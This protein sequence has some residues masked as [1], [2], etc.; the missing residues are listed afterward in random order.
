MQERA[1]RSMVGT[2]SRTSCR[3]LFKKLNILTLASIYTVEVTCFIRKYCQSFELNS[4]V[5][6]YNTQKK[7]DIHIQSN[8]TDI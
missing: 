8:K 1:I 7:K 2:S 6:N 4:N 5:H 3:Q